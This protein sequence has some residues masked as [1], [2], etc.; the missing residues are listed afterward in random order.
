MVSSGDAAS[1]DPEYK[2]DALKEEIRV[3]EVCIAVNHCTKT[4]STITM[5]DLISSFY[6]H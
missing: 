2:S 3:A 5:I 6:Q 1:Q 4:T